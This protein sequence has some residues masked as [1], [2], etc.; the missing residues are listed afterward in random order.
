VP[1]VPGTNLFITYGAVGT[2]PD[3]IAPLTGYINQ[4][5]ELAV[6]AGEQGGQQTTGPGE[7]DDQ[8][9]KRPRNC[10]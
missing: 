5:T 1:A 6:P 3:I 9:K 2:A 7:E 4:A 10:S 8:K